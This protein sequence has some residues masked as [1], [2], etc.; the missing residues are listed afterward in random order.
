MNDNPTHRAGPQAPIP[1]HDHAGAHA[2]AASA[3]A[4][5]VCG[6]TDIGRVRSHNEDA[7][8]IAD[9]SSAAAPFEVLR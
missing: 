9:L 8:T 7:F 1:A 6:A 5:S 2:G 4:V 3:V